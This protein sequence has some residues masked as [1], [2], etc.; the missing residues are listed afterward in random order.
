MQEQAGE[1]G[2]RMSHAVGIIGWLSPPWLY[3]PRWR[4]QEAKNISWPL[5][6]WCS[7]GKFGSANSNHV[8][9]LDAGR[10]TVFLHC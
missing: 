10:E 2:A 4:G 6:S 8:C 1:G 3:P 7:G 9:K 5:F